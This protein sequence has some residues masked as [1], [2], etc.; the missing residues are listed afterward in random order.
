MPNWLFATRSR[1]SASN[2]CTVSCVNK[3]IPPHCGWY[4][5]CGGICYSSNSYFTLLCTANSTR[6]RRSGLWIIRNSVRCVMEEMKRWVSILS[7]WNECPQT[8]FHLWVLISKRAGIP[9]GWRFLWPGVSNRGESALLAENSKG[10]SVPLAVV[11][12]GGSAALAGRIQ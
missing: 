8:I 6:A 5:Q 12:K 7:F 4:T 3:S 1:T 2:L 11:S 9:K 10:D